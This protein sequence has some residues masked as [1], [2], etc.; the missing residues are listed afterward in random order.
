M[1]LKSKKLLVQ[2]LIKTT[3]ID[4]LHFQETGFNFEAET[5]TEKSRV[6]AYIGVD[7]VRGSCPQRSKM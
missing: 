4:I 3:D 2:N 6:G 7:A 1:G 5:N